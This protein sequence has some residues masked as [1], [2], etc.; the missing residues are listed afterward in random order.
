MSP[1]SLPMGEILPS[2]Y[3]TPPPSSS[4]PP[5]IM[6]TFA[7]K[8]ELFILPVNPLI[9]L[10]LAVETAAILLTVKPHYLSLPPSLTETLSPVIV[11]KRHSCIC[12]YSFTDP[13]QQIMLL[14]GADQ[15][16]CGESVKTLTPGSSRRFPQA[17]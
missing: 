6:S 2:R 7:K 11:E 1:G 8:V 17:Q 3:K 12:R 15:Q 13:A 14:P 16:G 9:A 10:L 5:I 4:N